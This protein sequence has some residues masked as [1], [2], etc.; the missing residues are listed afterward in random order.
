MQRAAE[1]CASGSGATT[2]EETSQPIDE[3]FEALA[4]QGF[5]PLQIS[6]YKA[7]AFGLIDQ[8]KRDEIIGADRVHKRRLME[9]TIDDLGDEHADLRDELAAAMN[10][11]RLFA[12]LASQVGVKFPLSQAYWVWPITS[13]AEQ[14]ASGQGPD[15]L[16][17][18]AAEVL[19]QC[20]RRLEQSMEDAARAAYAKYGRYGRAEDARPQ[21][22]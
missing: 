14:V 1:A 11:P 4:D 10:D 5:P 22:L 17:W 18:L 2:D 20:Q 6:P 19:R 7:C 21:A 9:A 13:L 15:R 16:A 3:E 12:Q 8:A